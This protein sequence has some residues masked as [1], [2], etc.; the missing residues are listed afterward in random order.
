VD[1]LGNPLRFILTSGAAGDNPQAIPLLAGIQ[2]QEVVADR[3]YDADKTLAYVTEQ[4]GAVAT[5]PPKKCRAI[6][7]DC[8]YAAYR[9]RHLVECLIGQL[10]HFRR[11]AT[12][13]DKYASRYLAFVH[14]ASI[15][16]WLK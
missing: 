4:L 15:L 2:T 7:R 3:G 10:K 9:E 13:Y 8:D 5:I 14:L 6:Q 12:R 1:A 11:L 16:I